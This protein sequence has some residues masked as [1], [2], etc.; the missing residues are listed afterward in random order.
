MEGALLATVCSS[1]T[2][3]AGVLRGFGVS[4]SSPTDF[5]LAV[6]P[7]VFFLDLFFADSG[8]GVGV[9]WGDG[10]VVADGRFDEFSARTGDGNIDATIRSGSKMSSSWTMHTGD[11]NLHLALPA[12]FAANIDAHSGDGHVQSELPITVSGIFRENGLRGQMNGGGP[13]L[14][15]RTGDGDI[16]L[17]KVMGSL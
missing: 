9:W 11:G 17:T 8:L 13:T 12:N 6:F 5:A 14:E 1:S 2:C 3:G 15:L 7:V 4:S 10:N 16:R